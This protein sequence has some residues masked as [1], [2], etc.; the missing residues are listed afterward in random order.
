MHHVYFPKG[1]CST[2]IDF[3][4]ENNTIHNVKY[5]DLLG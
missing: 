4:I 3:D 2:R 5:S 1:V